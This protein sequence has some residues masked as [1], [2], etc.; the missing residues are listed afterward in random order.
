V[1]CDAFASSSANRFV[2]R[3]VFEK[4]RGARWLEVRGRR[5]AFVVSTA[6]ASIH[7]YSLAFTSSTPPIAL[8]AFR[9]GLGRAH[10]KRNRRST[11]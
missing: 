8:I 1:R 4:N 9:I 2:R 10:R 7:L 3:E 11:R 5:H 6:F